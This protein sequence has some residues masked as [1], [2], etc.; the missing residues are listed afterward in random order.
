MAAPTGAV[1]NYLDY[2]ALSLKSPKCA[3]DLRNCLPKLRSMYTNLSCISK[4]NNIRYST[5]R[6]ASVLLLKFVSVS[7]L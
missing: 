7:A 2:I 1:L 5:F 6:K 3:S 4:Y